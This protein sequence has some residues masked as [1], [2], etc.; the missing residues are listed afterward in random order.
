VPSRIWDV[1]PRE[2][3]DPRKAE[4]YPRVDKQDFWRLGYV[5]R[6]SNHSKGGTVRPDHDRPGRVARRHLDAFRH[7]GR[8]HRR[9]MAS[10]GTTARSTWA[11]GSIASMSA[12]IPTRPINAAARDNRQRLSRAMEQ[13]GFTGYANEWWHF[14]YSR[15]ASLKTVMDFPITPLAP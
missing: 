8:L 4:F 5:A 9:L 10:A 13:E 2:P 12:R 15:D 14:T 6:V 7:T 11:P 3:G 1:S